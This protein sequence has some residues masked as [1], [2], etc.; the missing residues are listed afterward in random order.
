PC[1]VVRFTFHVV[2][3]PAGVANSWHAHKTV[4]E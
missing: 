3:H 2:S 1:A 4:A